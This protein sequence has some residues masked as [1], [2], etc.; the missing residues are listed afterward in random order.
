MNTA[1]PGRRA[2]LVGVAV[3]LSLA[4]V[5]AIVAVVTR[6]GDET[7]TGDAP[8]AIAAG[9]STE[10]DGSTTTSIGNVGTTG[11]DGSVPGVGTT[12]P[13]GGGGPGATA[14]TTAEGSAATTP[15][16]PT[17][18][19]SPDSLVTVPTDTIPVAD[20]IPPDEVADF[21]T[22]VTAAI[23]DVEA[24]DGVAALPG[25]ISGPALRVTVRLT[26][27]S[28]AALDLGQTLVDVT[29][30]AD[31]TPGLA[32][33]E[34]GGAPLAGSLAP[35]ASAQGVYVFGIPVDERGQV[36]V[37][38]MYDVT[39]PIVVFEGPAPTP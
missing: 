28:A 12:L 33:G 10:A 34:P 1:V 23:V 24:V 2:A 37:T 39:A 13:V 6:G 36:Q 26:N 22:G 4:F 35:G 31:R 32:L 25:E 11:P 19:P 16:A 18:A 7:T 38:V 30:G 14:P 27:G 8:G 17:E 5:I 20:P 9:E 3:V 15:P 21:G 29:Y